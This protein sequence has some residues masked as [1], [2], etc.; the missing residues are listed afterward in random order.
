MRKLMVL[1][2]HDGVGGEEGGS[3]SRVE[4]SFELSTLSLEKLVWLGI[5]DSFV[6]ELMTSLIVII[7]KSTFRPGVS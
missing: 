2:I 5:P 7:T 3:E 1:L 6:R 4:H